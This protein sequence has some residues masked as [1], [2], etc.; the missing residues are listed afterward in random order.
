MKATITNIVKDGDRIKVFVSFSDGTETTYFHATD[1]TEA[2]ITSAITITLGEKEHAQHN[3]D[4]L[5]SKLI[6]ITIG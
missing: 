3:A 2:E 6:N 5:A 1:V 4:E